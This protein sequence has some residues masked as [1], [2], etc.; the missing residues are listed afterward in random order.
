MIRR[1]LTIPIRATRRAAFTLFELLVVI[2]VILALIAVTVPSFATLLES[3]SFSSA[4]NAV[5]GT[6]GNARALAISTGKPV[7]V[8][9][10]FDTQA[11]EYTL[12]VVEL[13]RDGTRADLTPGVSRAVDTKAWGL[14]PAEN[15]TPV[16]LPDGTAV[17]GMSFNHVAPRPT[18]AQLTPE[19]GALNGRLPDTLDERTAQW[20]AGEIFVD[21]D[22]GNWLVNPWIFPRNDPRLFIDTDDLTPAK[23]AQGLLLDEMWQIIYGDSV[24]G[25][26]VAADDAIRAVRHANS[27]VVMFSPDGTVVPMHDGDGRTVDFDFY[28]EFPDDPV[29]NTGS[30]GTRPE[31]Y[32]NAFLFDPEFIGPNV[33]TP[34]PNPEVILRSVDQ[35]AV[36]AFNRLVAGTGIDRP[37]ELHPATSAAPWP[38]F[39]GSAQYQAQPLNPT[40][41][42]LNDLVRSVTRW[43]DQ[44]AEIIGFDR[45]SGAAQRRRQLQ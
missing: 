2:V 22:N 16:S 25:V 35:L 29:D 14:R 17:F 28:L 34:T 18:R 41:E 36:V 32:D 3:A 44:N 12:Q 24:P 23:R 38:D 40:D 11:R 43:I 39:R 42:D 27:F 20:Y 33:Q 19:N 7:G 10:F 4:V 1:L 13:V 31:P 21:P 9:F 15:T 6:L 45:Y 5:T 37:W 26:N 8:A 30:A